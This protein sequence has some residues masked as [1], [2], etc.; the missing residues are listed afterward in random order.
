M[1]ARMQPL[2][3][4]CLCSPRDLMLKTFESKPRLHDQVVYTA[5]R[6]VCWVYVTHV[7]SGV[8]LFF[9][10]LLHGLRRRA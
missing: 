5:M 4:T 6:C 2:P 9:C 1:Y 8:P 3:I 7:A 10:W